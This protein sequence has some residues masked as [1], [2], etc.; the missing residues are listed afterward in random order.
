MADSGGERHGIV[1]SRLPSTM[2]SSVIPSEASVEGDH[3]ASPSRTTDAVTSDHP[4]PPPSNR[5]LP[6]LAS[7]LGPT[8][9]TDDRDRTLHSSSS[10]SSSSAAAV[11]TTITRPLMPTFSGP[12]HA[13]RTTHEHPVGIDGIPPTESHEGHV[14]SDQTGPNSAAPR[15]ARGGRK[16]PTT[17]KKRI[18]SASKATFARATR[19]PT[20][21]SRPTS[22]LSDHPLPPPS[23]HHPNGDE[24]SDV[25]LFCVCRKPDNHSWMIA[26]DGGCNDWFHG[27]C[28]DMTEDEGRLIDAYI[29]TPFL[30]GPARPLFPPRFRLTVDLAPP[31]IRPRVRDHQQTYDLEAHLSSSGLSSPG[32]G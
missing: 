8:T 22:I 2:S 19:A 3:G 7:G 9:S 32:S 31:R 14:V 26:C 5:T 11:T 4:A 25:E 21:G 16:G 10:S 23:E 27:A 29:C 24:P 12:V 17:S 1:T 6:V 13:K 28:V 20:G 18:A 30:R 15:S